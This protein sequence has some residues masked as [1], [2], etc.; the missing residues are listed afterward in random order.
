L[1]NGK[2]EKRSASPEDYTHIRWTVNT[3]PAGGSGSVGFQ[4]RMK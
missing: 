1:P 3:I 2:T 4:V